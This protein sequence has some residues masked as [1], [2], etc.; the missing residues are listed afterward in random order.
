VRILRGRERGR[1][2]RRTEKNWRNEFRFKRVK[3][4]WGCNWDSQ[5]NIRTNLELKRRIVFMAIGWGR[6]H[7]T[8]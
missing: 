6:R 2:R 1:R 5:N 4:N 8:V 7:L 3:R